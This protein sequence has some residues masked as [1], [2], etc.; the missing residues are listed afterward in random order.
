M[1]TTIFIL[2]NIVLFVVCKSSKVGHLRHHRNET[3]NADCPNWNYQYPHVLDGV[4]KTIFL[5][6]SKLQNIFEEKKIIYDGHV[7]LFPRE[8]LEYSFFA[9]HHTIRTIVETGFNAGHS[10]VVLLSANPNAKLFS[11][12][13]QLVAEGI[14]Y[15]EE[16][17][18]NRFTKIMGDSKVTL[19]KW[20]DAFDG[21]IDLMVIDGNHDYPAPRAD[22]MLMIRKAHIGTRYIFDGY[23]KDCED[24]VAEGWAV[25]LRKGRT[26]IS[27]MQGQ[28]EISIG[29]R[30]GMKLNSKGTHGF[31]NTYCMGIIVKIPKI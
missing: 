18:S 24:V 19:P 6:L 31:V 20:L 13:L 30:S 27:A 1:N 15:V 11:F 8:I 26:T 29:H 28:D 25:E 14:K 12:T 2:C 21:T 22:F 4:E 5:D 3:E 9:S 23:T 7:G 16:N 10:T 17:Y